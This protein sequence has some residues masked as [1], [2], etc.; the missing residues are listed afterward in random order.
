MRR[1]WWG[2]GWQEEAV[3]P[4]ERAELVARLPAH[5][6][7]EPL[8]VPAV[9]GLGLPEPRVAPPAAVAACCSAEP[10]VRAG[11]TFGKAYRDVV[12]AL[13]GELSHPPDLVAFPRAESD[14]V[15]LLDWASGANVALIPY[16]GG[17]SVVGGVEYRGG[18]HAGVV[19]VDLSGL[20]RVL[21][22]DAVSRA[23]CVQAR[24][25]WGRS[26][27]GNWVCTG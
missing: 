21:E 12:R 6:V 2:W 14:V 18:D 5:W 15:A 1:S 8:P 7:S 19:S 24:G 16:G 20:D 23:A 3:G 9:A 17:S 11:H 25:S 13:R 10:E 27:S 4:A 26:W 22:V